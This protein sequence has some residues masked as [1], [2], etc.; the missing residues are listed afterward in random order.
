MKKRYIESFRNEDGFIVSVGS[1]MFKVD[2]RT[3]HS[4]VNAGI[5]KE[6]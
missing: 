6:A 2:T 5:W 3:Y 1:D 4:L